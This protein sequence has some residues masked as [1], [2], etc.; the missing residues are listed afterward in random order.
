MLS[1]SIQIQ[2]W[3]MQTV[4]WRFVGFV[5]SVVGL[6]CYALSSSF[7]NLFGHWN[8][9]KI[10]LYF[11][12]SF[13]VIFMTLFAKVWQFSTSS[14]LLKTRMAVLVLKTT[15][16][17]SFFYDKAVNGKPDVYIVISC[18]AFAFMSLSL[19]KQTQCGCEVDLLNFFLGCLI[20]L[21]MKISLWLFFVGA[22]FS[23]CLVILRSCSDITLQ[24]EYF[25]LQDHI[26]IQVD[27]QEANDNSVVQVHSQQEDLPA[28]TLDVSA[29]THQVGTR[30]DS[31]LMPQL[32]ACIKELKKKDLIF[33]IAL[34]V[35][36]YERKNLKGEEER[37]LMQLLTEYNMDS[38]QIIN[39]L[40]A[41]DA[42]YEK[43]CC[44]VYNSCRREF[45][46]KCLKIMFLDFNNEK[47]SVKVKT[48]KW[49]EASNIALR[50]LLPSER[51]LC[52]GIFFGFSSA[53]DHSFLEIC[54][55]FTISLLSF[56]YN[57][58]VRSCSWNQFCCSLKVFQTLSDLIPE[59][60]ALFSDVSPSLMNEATTIRKRLREAIRENFMEL[61]NRICSE[62]VQK[63]TPNGGI[64]PISHHVKRCLIVV[65]EGRHTLEQV[66][67]EYPTV[68]DR[69]GTSSSLPIQ[70]E[71]V[72]ELLDSNL[73]A[74]SKNY[75][76]PA[77]GY[78]FMMNNC[79]YI[80]QRVK[81][82]ELATTLGDDWIK[83]H[84]TKFHKNLKDYQRTW[85]KVLNILKMEGNESAESMKKKLKLF[86]K[87]FKEMCIVQ[88][89]WFVLDEQLREQLRICIQDNLLPSY[90][91]FIWRFQNLYGK[92]AYEYIEYGMYD[93]DALL[94]D[95]FRGN[96][97]SNLKTGKR[98]PSKAALREKSDCHEN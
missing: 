92:H 85:D 47:D 97:I 25:E 57:L 94:N 74:R 63:D 16:V 95:L 14:T 2:R 9:F 98:S 62:K 22:G 39:S 68:G 72:M 15:T 11:I 67:N 79:S 38:V 24:S 88:S 65:L 54:K 76:D 96:E 78:L 51:R 23:Y 7:N 45:L 61:L 13:I 83:K 3:L 64:D 19:S 91:N 70:M 89:T 55:E 56:P 35:Y 52:N 46:E 66:L 77:L 49:M 60:E 30:V 75:T 87:E 59:F 17:Y 44:R 33:S 86:N 81:D 41:R 48:E 84:T 18:V 6:L 5:S 69:K 71:Q 53:A 27:S 37:R 42:G 1:V 21:L 32:V 8:F 36:A 73:E 4:V 31:P 28:M 26:A 40:M 34:R 80:V 58:A 43:E 20:L 10:F 50:I 90:G 29:V 12:F 82:N 93:I